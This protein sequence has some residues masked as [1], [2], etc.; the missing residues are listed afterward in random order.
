MLMMTMLA[1][2]SE[3]LE[4]DLTSADPL[5][6]AFR[7]ISTRLPSLDDQHRRR[8][9]RRRRRRRRVDEDAWRL[10]CLDDFHRSHHRFLRRALRLLPLRRLLLLHLLPFPKWIQLMTPLITNLKSENSC[11]DQ[12]LNEA[13]PGLDQH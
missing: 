10:R 7:S 11:V 13:R 12:I 5:A 9:R 2:F 6:G 8:H 3:R 1:S 4:G